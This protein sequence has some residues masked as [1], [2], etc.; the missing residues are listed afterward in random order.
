MNVYWEFI[1][2][3]LPTWLA[4]NLI[5]VIGLVFMLIITAWNYIKVFFE[6]ECS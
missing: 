3:L 4:P 6:I 5:T 2:S 1:V